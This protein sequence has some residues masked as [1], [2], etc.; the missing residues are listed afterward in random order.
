[1]TKEKLEQALRA[2]QVGD[3]RPFEDICQA[4]ASLIE[5]TVLRFQGIC[6]GLEREDLEQE[7]RIALYRAAQRYDFSKDQVTFGLFAKICLRNC[8]ISLRRKQAA[9]QRTRQKPPVKPKHNRFSEI[10]VNNPCTE[11]ILACLSPLEKK[12][13]P[14]YVKG[15]SYQKIA[16]IL[17]VPVKS[18]DNAMYRI[19][20]KIRILSADSL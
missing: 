10:D 15:C 7:A 17:S 19:K 1:M 3:D 16:D 4:Y 6:P 8:M 14:L 9:A 12:V 20:R 2:I 11:K 13:L 5:S 18:V